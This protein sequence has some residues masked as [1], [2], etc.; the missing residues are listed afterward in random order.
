MEKRKENPHAASGKVRRGK[1]NL[2]QESGFK[3]FYYYHSTSVSLLFSFF[4][5]APNSN[6]NPTHDD[7]QEKI[8]KKI[9]KPSDMEKRVFLLQ[10][11][12]L[13]MMLRSHRD[14][15]ETGSLT[16]PVSRINSDSAK[17]EILFPFQS[18]KK[19]KKKIHKCRRFRV[20]STPAL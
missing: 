10:R 3:F 19:K 9:L 17:V 2:R 4:C 8:L 12:E 5:G 20:L 15:E 1:R 18:Q 16:H 13:L 7:A 11:C 14:K 6:S